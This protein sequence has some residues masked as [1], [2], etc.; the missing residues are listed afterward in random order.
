MQLGTLAEVVRKLK[1][2]KQVTGRANIERNEN[3]KRRKDK[4]EP[5]AGPGKNRK[6][7]GQQSSSRSCSNSDGETRL[8]WSIGA[9]PVDFEIQ[10]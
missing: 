2:L 5:V 1:I 4:H 3:I 9:N 10:A 8:H 7:T 6:C